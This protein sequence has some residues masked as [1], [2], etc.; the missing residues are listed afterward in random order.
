MSILNLWTVHKLWIRGI[1]RE[2]SPFWSFCAKCKPNSVRSKITGAILFV[3][4]HCRVVQREVCS[5]LPEIFPWDMLAK[6]R[7]WSYGQQSKVRTRTNDESNSIGLRRHGN[8]SRTGHIRRRLKTL[9]GYREKVCRD[10]DVS[11]RESWPAKIGKNVASL[12][13]EGQTAFCSHSCLFVPTPV[14]VQIN[15]L[16]SQL[17][18]RLSSVCA[19]SLDFDPVDSGFLGQQLCKE[20]LKI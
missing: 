13:Y 18:L 9:A 15:W 5:I 14:P 4:L 7:S 8:V 6:S 17:S 19:L 10:G 3:Y 12:R 16:T 1:H 2:T 11:S 20:I